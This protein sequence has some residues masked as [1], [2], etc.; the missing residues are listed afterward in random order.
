MPAPAGQDGTYSTNG[1]TRTKAHKKH[2]SFKLA[3]LPALPQMQCWL[4]LLF[5]RCKVVPI[6]SRCQ[7][8]RVFNL[9]LPT[10]KICCH[11]YLSKPQ[12]L[13]RFCRK[14]KSHA[15]YSIL[16]L[17]FLVLKLAN[18]LN[19]SLLSTSTYSAK[20]SSERQVSTFRVS[21]RLYRT[22][23]G[24]ELEMR[25]ETMTFVSRIIFLHL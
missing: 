3:R 20:I 21:T 6:L 5:F 8:S 23:V 14:L 18:L 24:M 1:S 15:I 22:L 7:N 11:L 19:L 17:L 4:N 9:P 2:K 10:P 25:A 16:L 12:F 13:C